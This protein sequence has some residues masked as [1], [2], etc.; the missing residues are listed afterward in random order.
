MLAFFA[1][2]VKKLQ[3]CYRCLVALNCVV[4]LHYATASCV[5]QEAVFARTV[6]FKYCNY[7]E[8]SVALLPVL[9]SCLMY[10]RQFLFYLKSQT[11]Q[12]NY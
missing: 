12:S 2:I 3:Y 7:N 11:E 6:E 8:H 1:Q 10:L 4:F 5:S 9:F